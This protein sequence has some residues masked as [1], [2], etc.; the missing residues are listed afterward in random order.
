[1]IRLRSSRT[2]AD[3][4]P[5]S[6]RHSGLGGSAAL[7]ACTR[8]FS[9]SASE[10]SKRWTSR[11]ITQVPPSLWSTTPFTST[12]SS[13][14]NAASAASSVFSNTISSTEPSRSSRVANISSLP[15]RDRIFFD[16]V[17][18][19]PILTH[20][21]SLRSITSAQRQSALASSA[22]RTRL[23]GWSEMKRPIDSFSTASSSVRSNS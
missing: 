20:S 3:M 17:I 5:S 22:S 12:I 6:V 4:P 10:G 2:A 1:M 23:S 21:W 8:A 7:T 16:A 14:C 9:I 15:A 18:M 19:P 13:I 11:T